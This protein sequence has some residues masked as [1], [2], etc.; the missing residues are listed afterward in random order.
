[1]PTIVPIVEGHGDAEAVRTLIN[2][3]A[4]ASSNAYVDVGRPIR[5]PRQL[6]VKHGELEKQIRLAANK[7]GSDGRILVLLDADDDCPAELGPSLL[8][9]AQGARG[10]RRIAVV[11]AKVEYEAWFAAAAE[12]LV[13]PNGLKTNVVAPV[14][15]ESLPSPKGWISNRMA[16]RRYSPTTHQAKFTAR[17]DL[18]MARRAPSF[19]KMWRSVADL[20]R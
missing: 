8:A 18:A 15:P 1:M 17:F 6:V 16:T 11:L 13:W 19:D 4:L 7:G 14:D 9:R 5:A 20:L 3:I 2:R 12:S 10:D